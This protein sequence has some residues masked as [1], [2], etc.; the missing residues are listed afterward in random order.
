MVAVSI[1]SIGLVLVIRSFLTCSGALDSMQNRLKAAQFLEG[2]MS[3]VELK[4]K[5]EDGV[6]VEDKQEEVT[7]GNRKATF[8]TEIIASQIE[9]SEEAVKE[10]LDEARLSLFWTESGRNKDEVMSSYM[11]NK[12]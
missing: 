8:K 6:Q 10:P 7:L 3:E 1:L 5:E 12:K 2:K 9:E 4:A 11:E